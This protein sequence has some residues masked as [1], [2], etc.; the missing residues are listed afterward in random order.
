MKKE[1]R[2]RMKSKKKK[3]IELNK[4]VDEEINNEMDNISKS[5]KEEISEE[6]D[7]LKKGDKL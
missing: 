2:T 3:F 7:E 1:I 4:S 5:N 6:K